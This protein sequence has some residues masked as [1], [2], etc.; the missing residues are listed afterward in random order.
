M[1]TLFCLRLEVCPFWGLRFYFLLQI[2]IML[3][4]DIVSAAKQ[5]RVEDIFRLYSLEEGEGGSEVRHTVIS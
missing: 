2:I 1:L 3:L 4:Q 5:Y